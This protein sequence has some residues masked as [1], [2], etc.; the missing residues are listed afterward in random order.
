M[1]RIFSGLFVTLTLSSGL[2]F[3]RV[4]AQMLRPSMMFGDSTHRKP[5]FAKD[6]H[7]VWFEKR[8]LLYYSVPTGKDSTG[9]DRWGIGIAESQDLSTWR[10][11]AEI[12]PV[13]DYERKGF[14][15][16]GALVRDGKVHLFY[17]TYGNGRSD[18]I[19]HASSTDGIHFERNPTN[20]IFHPEI[21][22]WSCGRAIDAD[23]VKFN[24]QYFLYFATRDPAY[25][26]QQLGVA[27]A[28]ANT[29]FE[30][31][32]WKLLS[33]N[34]PILKPDYPWEGECI[35]APSVIQRGNELVMFYAGAYNNWPQQI[36]VARSTDGLHWERQ[37]TKPFLKNGDPGSWNASESG[38]PH[39]FTTPTSKTYLFYQG[40]NDKGKSWFLS[41]REVKWQNATPQLVN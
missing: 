32:D 7:V 15:A 3:T 38:H 22:Q 37:Q 36:G 23:V 18:A 33:T 13:A 1:L 28:P 10:K 5:A 31:Q 12:P 39:L 20:P 26:I 30:R 17:Q 16:P 21:S 25:R 27:V 6:P 9:A 24:N 8:Y 19:C 34:G 14:C 11:V 40:N 41:N 29:N 2:S 35:E 4:T